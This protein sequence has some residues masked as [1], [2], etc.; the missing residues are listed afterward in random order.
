MAIVS[1]SR[2]PLSQKGANDDLVRSLSHELEVLRETVR[3]FDEQALIESMSREVDALRQS[4]AHL[5]GC[6]H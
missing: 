6:S 2:E 4:V 3:R 5:R 1:S